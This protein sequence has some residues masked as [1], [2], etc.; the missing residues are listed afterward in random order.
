M[1]SGFSNCYD[2]NAYRGFLYGISVILVVTASIVGCFG[3][4]KTCSVKLPKSF[5]ISYYCA[6]ISLLMSIFGQFIDV[7][8][9][10]RVIDDHTCENFGRH[11]FFYVVLGYFGYSFGLSFLNLAYI[12]RL[13]KTFVE[14]NLR[15]KS[16]VYKILLSLFVIIPIISNL[17][18]FS[19]R[20]C[21]EFL[22]QIGLSSYVPVIIIWTCVIG[23]IVIL[24]LYLKKLKQLLRFTNLPSDIAIIVI[25]YVNCVMLTSTTS[26]FSSIF[27]LI[28]VINYQFN[29]SK[30]DLWL[31]HNLFRLMD[32]TINIIAIHLQFKYFTPVYVILCNNSK[33][34]I[35]RMLNVETVDRVNSQADTS[36]IEMAESTVAVGLEP[37]TT[38]QQ[39]ATGSE[40]SSSFSNSTFIENMYLCKI[41]PVIVLFD[42]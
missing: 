36:T 26:V 1:G 37:T 28:L 4:F 16:L 38:S 20:K 2:M 7:S 18:M 34:S 15:I 29:K 5:R 22:R 9:R 27:T 3:C 13:N 21:N 25:K 35:G 39:N 12:I 40:P 19:C 31:T 32:T 30:S 42:E 23:Q 6:L 14:E 33:K 24:F 17:T 8:L 11:V 41:C 10:L